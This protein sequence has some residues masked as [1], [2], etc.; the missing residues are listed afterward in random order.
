MAFREVRVYEV[1][2]VLRLWLRGKGTR[3]I[4]AM[5]GVDRKTV[6]RYIVAPAEAGLER[7]TDEDALDDELMAKVCERARPSSF[8]VQL[9]SR[10]S[11]RQLLHHPVANPGSVGSRRRSVATV[12]GRAWGS[13]HP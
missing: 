9:H 10:H 11:R 8:I 5:V 7:S 13:G 3:P 6:Q 12:S 4:S 2:E 1:K